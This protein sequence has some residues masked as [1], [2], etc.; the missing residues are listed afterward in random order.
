M[1]FVT[2]DGSHSLFS[3][4][5]GE[6]YHSRHGAIQESQHVFIKMGL[7]EIVKTNREVKILEIGLGTG[8]NALLSMLQASAEK[9]KVSYTA[10]EA[11]PISID[12]VRSLNYLQML[13]AADLAP[14]FLQMHLSP[15]QEFVQLTDDFEIY[16]CSSQIENCTF[17]RAYDCIYFDAF[18]PQAQPELWT[19]T[20]FEKMFQFCKPGGI[21][22]T[23]CA[24]GDVRRNMISAGF[25]VEKVP[26]PPGKREMLR[27]RRPANK[28]A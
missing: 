26:G 18:A 24:K 25:E 8:L 9:C 13:D 17:D 23:Y 16:K 11:Y 21:L 19:T 7:Q 20:I 10:V 1:L 28:N 6:A 2:Q 4:Q 12:Q 3:A 22:V 27:A 15:W 14:E 5:I